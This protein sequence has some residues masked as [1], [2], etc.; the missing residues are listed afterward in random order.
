MVVEVNNKQGEPM[1]ETTHARILKSQHKTIKIAA[2]ERET[3]FQLLLKR[4][5]TVGIKMMQLEEKK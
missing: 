4:I 1:E 3:T 5:I 2:R